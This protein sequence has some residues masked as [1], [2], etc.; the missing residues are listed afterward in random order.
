MSPGVVVG[1]DDPVGVVELVGTAAA[2]VG[3]AVVGGVVD[4]V[5]DVVVLIVESAHPVLVRVLLSRVTA[6]V[7]ARSRPTMVA[8]VFAVMDVEAITVPIR[9]DAVPRVA[10]LGTC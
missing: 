1:V 3:G 6:P 9:C 10:E 2:V 5:V 4:V 7:E 8:P